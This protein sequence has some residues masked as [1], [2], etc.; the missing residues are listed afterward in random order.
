MFHDCNALQKSDEFYM[1]K[2]PVGNCSQEF[3]LKAS[4]EETMKIHIRRCLEDAS[5]SEGHLAGKL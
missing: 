4:E 3:D 2:C 5:R 1:A